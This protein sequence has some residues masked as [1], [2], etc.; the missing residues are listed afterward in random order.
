M[1]QTDR[2]D[3]SDLQQKL[4]AIDLDDDLEDFE[5]INAELRNDSEKLASKPMLVAANKIDM[6]DDETLNRFTEYVE[7]K[8]L[9]VYPMS[10]P[11]HEGVNELL[12]AA[13]QIATPPMTGVD[14]R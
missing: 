2:T 9:K 5:K 10:A 1:L 11:I 8:G 3:P 13:L 6:A 7:S 14:L 4:D 12:A